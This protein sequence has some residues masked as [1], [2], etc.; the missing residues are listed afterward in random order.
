MRG[1]RA[2]EVT[3]EVE[4]CPRESAAFHHIES[5]VEEAVER[6]ETLVGKGSTRECDEV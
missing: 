3:A 2:S 4:N 1:L 5:G 6:R